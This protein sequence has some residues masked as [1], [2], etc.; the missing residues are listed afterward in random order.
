MKCAVLVFPGSNCDVDMYKAVED[1]LG[2]PVEYVWY[3]R[4]DIDEFDC[5]L[6]PGGF[7]YGDY[8][9][10]GAMAS[11]AP[12]L[13][14]VQKA[15]EAGKLIMGIC[16]G[17]QVLTE[18]RLLPG[19]LRRNEK[20][21]FRCETVELRVENNNTAFTSQYEAGEIIRIPIA[22]GDGN[23]YCDEE[24]LSEMKKNNQ[25][26]FRYAGENPNGSIDDIAG[27]MNKDGNVLGMMPHPER[28]VHK[29]LGSDDGKRVFTS[30]LQSWREKNGVT[31]GA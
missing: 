17:F 30:I 18:A 8:L 7:S 14:A 2:Q 24:T 27:V 22:H 20:L 5:I 21:K 25:I 28:A 26:V 1:C 13:A 9:R 23:Y 10:P 15:A 3:T 4:T 19:A 29:W 16:N 6:L 31:H 12:V 11:M